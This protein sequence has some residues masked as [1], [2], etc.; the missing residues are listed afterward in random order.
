[1]PEGVDVADYFGLDQTAFIQADISPRDSERII[2]ETKDYIIQFDSWGITS[3][4]WKHANSTPHF[5]DLTIVDRDSWE[6][7]K[8]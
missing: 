2:E 3:K 5:M 8:A 6:T 7:A 4:N 1:M